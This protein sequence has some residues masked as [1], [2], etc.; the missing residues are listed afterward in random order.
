MQR[1]EDVNLKYTT[2]ITPAQWVFFIWDFI[3]FWIF[4]MFTYFL[5]GLCRRQV[6]ILCHVAFRQF[7]IAPYLYSSAGVSLLSHTLVMLHV[8][9]K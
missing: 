4:S 6:L 9:K 8:E 5:A 7:V 3:Y 1:T 2:P